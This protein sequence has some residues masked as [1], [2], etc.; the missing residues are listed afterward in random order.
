MA[1]YYVD[2][3]SGSDGNAGTSFG[4]AFAST[5]KG[6]DTAVAGEEVRL[7]DTGV[8][9]LSSRLDLDTNAGVIFVAYD[10]TG[11]APLTSGH[12]TIDGSLLGLTDLVQLSVSGITMQGV[13][14]TAGPAYNIKFSGSSAY[15]QM[16]R[17]R[18]DNAGTSGVYMDNVTHVLWSIDSEIDHNTKYGVRQSTSSRGNFYGVGGS[19]HHNGSG[20][21]WV[22]AYI[23]VSNMAVYRN[24]GDGIRN[25][26]SRTNIYNCTVYGNTG[27]GIDTDYGGNTIVGCT[28]AANGGYGLNRN[29]VNENI[30]II[31]YNHY[32]GNTSGETD[33]GA[34]PGTHNQSGDPLF[35]DTTDGSEDFT[36]AD[37]SPLD[38]TGIGGVDIGARKA[39][40]PA[41]G[42]GYV[43]R[44]GLQAIGAGVCA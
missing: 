7:C 6:A 10:A 39:A 30:D 35:A 22:G 21:V 19:V 42:G 31:D 36:P 24:G 27:D 33:L 28:L 29:G 18:V 4:A 11:T 9:Y 34:T 17:C 13:R 23:M 3:V 32:H 43:N 16:E 2:P 8:E 1:T 37:G 12:Y 41:G 20:G 44:E 5:Q 38:G 26:E 40:D 14:L 15:M 25:L